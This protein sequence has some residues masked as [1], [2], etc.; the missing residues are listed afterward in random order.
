MMNQEKFNFIKSG[1]FEVLPKLNS[2]TPAK[3]GK[4]NAQQ[5]LEHV[6]AFFYVSTEKIQ[7]PLVTPEEHLPK[8]REFLYSDK[9]FRENTKAP[10]TVLG[11]DPLPLAQPTFSIA[12]EKLQKAVHY[13]FTYFENSPGK[14]TIHP[15]FGALTFDEWV[16]LHYKHV[17]HHFK[18]FGLM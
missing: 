18:Q 12:I 6:T 9:E 16:L 14:T 10:L 7:F 5:M 1:M 8:Y 3:W 13:F 11:E 4:M 2:D 17:T 15:V